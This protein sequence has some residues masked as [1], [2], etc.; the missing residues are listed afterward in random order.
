MVE[1]QQFQPRQVAY[2]VR[3]SDLY[4]GQYIEQDGWQ[5]NFI[6][7][8]D[9]QV[10]RVNVIA[11]VIDKQVGENLGTITIDDGSGNLQVRA[12][13][14]ESVK[15][16]LIEIGDVVII[17]GRP[18]KYANQLFISYEIVKKLDP[19]WG[20]V[21]TNEL[22]VQEPIVQNSAPIVE[23]NT[24]V[25]NNVGMENVQ[26]ET[27]QDN[28]EDVEKKKKVLDLIRDEDNGEG[29]DI[30][31]VI[32]S[33]GFDQITADQLIQDLIKAGEVYENVAGKIKLL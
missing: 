6:Q 15:L 12:F 32:L 5:P 2:K 28:S 1:E 19:L 33:S 8:G 30:D 11:S 18:R 3:I 14:E 7:V 16:N 29:A 23:N 13:N 4:R 25:Q 9:K 10:S 27:I 31:N 20:K 22:G 26:I 21:R 24:P 17:I